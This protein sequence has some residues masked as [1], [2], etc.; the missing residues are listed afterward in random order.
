MGHTT[1]V[2]AFRIYSGYLGLNG[3]EPPISGAFQTA[4]NGQLQLNYTAVANGSGIFTLV[5]FYTAPLAQAYGQ[6]GLV[7]GS[8]GFYAEI[9]YTDS[10]NDPDVWDT[11]FVEPQE[12]NPQ[13]T[14]DQ[15]GPPYPTNYRQFHEF[16]VNESGH[17]T[18][19]SGAYRGNWIQWAGGTTG[20]PVAL[21]LAS[22][23]ALG[24][25]TI[26]LAS[27]WTGDTS[28]SAH[29]WSIKF[30]SGEI[31][32]A[33]MTNGS[34]GPF[35]LSSALSSAETVNASINTFASLTSGGFTDTT[36]LDY[37]VEHIFGAS[38]DPV[39]KTYNLWQDGVQIGSI[40]TANVNSNTFRDSLHY[41]MIVATQSR[42]AHVL[43]S[44]T[45]RYISM[46]A[47]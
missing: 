34:P 10:S 11:M 45:V 37:T 8:K 13:E 24:A 9:A 46:W 4:A 1:S 14:A 6:A 43:H 2:G 31:R 25:T 39:G 15:P 33:V 28:F 16:D 42:G 19:Q 23:P 29:K 3:S 22:A 17:G 35:T 40:S 21:T 44:M 30:N 41:M 47:P 18:D 32:Q 7:L 26:T 27:P 12:H 20:T 36:P 5:P 38:Y